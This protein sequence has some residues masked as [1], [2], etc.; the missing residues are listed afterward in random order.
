MAVAGASALVGILEE[1]QRR[2]LVGP[3]AIEAQVSHAL[4][5]GE[6]SGSRALSGGGL[7]LD[8]GTG[9]GLP[10]LVLAAAWPAS[11]WVLVDSRQRSVTFCREAVE[12]LGLETRV[13]VVHGRAEV[14]GRHPTHRGRYQLVTARGFGPAAVTAE[15]AAPFL[16]MGGRLTVSEPPGA[17]GERWPGEGLARLGLTIA[18][19]VAAEGAGFAVLEQVAPCPPAY[20]RREGIPAKRPLFG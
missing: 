16:R 19:V 11:R 8:L 18:R 4:A 13:E 3:G 5:L 10:G 20:P 12:R 15:C 9:G 2:G 6:A 17:A 14:V 1:A 7:A